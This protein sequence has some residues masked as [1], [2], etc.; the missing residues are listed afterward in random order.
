MQSRRTSSVAPGQHIETICHVDLGTKAFITIF[1]FSEPIGDL[2]IISKTMPK[3][4]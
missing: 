2:Q 1:A 3:D 4:C